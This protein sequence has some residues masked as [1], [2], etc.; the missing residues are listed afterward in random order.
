MVFL[1][2]YCLTQTSV[3]KDII[4]SGLCELQFYLLWAYN[5]TVESRCLKFSFFLFIWMELI[6]FNAAYMQ[7]NHPPKII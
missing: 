1:Q 7:Q 5:I 3:Q 6:L 4:P 2:G